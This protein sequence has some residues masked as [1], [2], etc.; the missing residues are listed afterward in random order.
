MIHLGHQIGVALLT[1]VVV[2]HVQGEG[3][4]DG[5]R[6]LEVNPHRDSSSIGEIGV[7]RRDDELQQV[8][9]GTPDQNSLPSLLVE[10]ETTLE[11]RACLVLVVCSGHEAETMEVYGE[12]VLGVLGFGIDDAVL[13]RC[14][15][16]LHV[17]LLHPMLPGLLVFGVGNGDLGSICLLDLPSEP[18]ASTE[19]LHL[20]EAGEN[21]AHRWHPGFVGVVRDDL[22][23]VAAQLLAW[24]IAEN[25]L[26]KQLL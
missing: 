14:V 7:H 18:P 4:I 20:L 24:V 15:R 19:Q 11:A 2:H 10:E 16:H 17:K 8:G 22:Q 9:L 12:N 13:L 23:D 6:A 3:D 25:A 5:G 26:G 1:S 21:A